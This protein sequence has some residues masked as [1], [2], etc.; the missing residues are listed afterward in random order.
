MGKFTHYLVTRF[1]VP[2]EAWPE[3]KNGHR[4]L[5]DAW[6]SDRLYL[7]S[8]YCV[9]SVRNQANQNFKWI[10][11]CDITTPEFTRN[12]ISGTLHDLH[13]ASIRF[14]KSMP[15]MLQD[16]KEILHQSSTPYVITTR[17][18]N[19]DVISRDFT[20]TIQQHFVA[21]DKYIINLEGG[22]FYDPGHQVLTSMRI[23]DC[24]N[25]ISLV[26]SSGSQK[27]YSVFGFPHT[28]VPE[29]IKIIG[30]D[31]GMHWI[32]I[33]HDRNIRSE[34]KGRPV[35]VVPNNLMKT[36]G[37][38]ISISVVN[39]FRYIFRRILAR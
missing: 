28:Q 27:L 32:R 35:W 9:P 30:V 15:D 3:D 34:L 18:D 13:S 6:M 37:F 17:L 29:D 36:F 39:T 19:D 11:Y 21:K 33:V 31:E 10:I 38:Q 20:G 22:F 1:N 4:V 25:F 26:E 16:L 5:D 14:V 24:N 8:A 23:P 2:I 12:M 7:F